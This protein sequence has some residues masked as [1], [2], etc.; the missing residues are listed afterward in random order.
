VCRA[1]RFDVEIDV[2]RLKNYNFPGTNQIPAKLIQAGSETCCDVHKLTNATGKKEELPDQG[3][4]S[5]L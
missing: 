3:K 2:E 5:V 1:S 4:E